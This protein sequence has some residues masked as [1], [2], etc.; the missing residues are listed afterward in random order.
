MSWPGE[1]QRH[2]LSRR[3]VKTKK[4]FTDK[5][6]RHPIKVTWLQED[7]TGNVMRVSEEFKDRKTAKE[8]IERL[9]KSAKKVGK[10]V[11][12]VSVRGGV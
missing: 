11:K 12:I 1:S 2:S 8:H 4:T 9:Q 5:R 3:R 7:K 10:P 6:L